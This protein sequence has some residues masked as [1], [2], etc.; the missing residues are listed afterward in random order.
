MGIN[1]G[2]TP[3]VGDKVVIHGVVEGHINGWLQVRVEADPKFL[4]SMEPRHL[5][6]AGVEPKEKP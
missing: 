1:N 3:A 5:Q 4:L 2:K 6:I